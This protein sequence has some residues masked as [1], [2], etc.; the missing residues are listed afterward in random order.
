MSITF[1]VGLLAMHLLWLTQLHTF[2][3][4]GTLLWALIV[5]NFQHIISISWKKYIYMYFAWKIKI[6][7]D[8]FEMPRNFANPLYVLWAKSLKYISSK[9]NHMVCFVFVSWKTDVKKFIFNLLHAKKAPTFLVEMFIEW[10]TCMQKII[11]GWKKLKNYM[12][13]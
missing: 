5:Y 2:C 10:E 6:N 3:H 9:F 1:C 7:W 13:E 11:K 4:I 12:F 8:L